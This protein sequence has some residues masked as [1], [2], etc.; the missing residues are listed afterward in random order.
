MNNQIQVV[1]DREFNIVANYKFAVEDKQLEGWTTTGYAFH[2]E[3]GSFIE[4]SDGEGQVM[5]MS[6]DLEV[7][8]CLYNA[9]IA[10]EHLNNLIAQCGMQ[11]KA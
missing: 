6:F 8:M 3:R 7:I 11:V 10:A 1:A 2:N 5:D 9:R 4:F